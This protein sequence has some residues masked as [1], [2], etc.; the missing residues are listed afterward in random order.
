M[1][2]GCLCFL[3]VGII[4]SMS[5]SEP[6]LIGWERAVMAAEKVKDRLRRAVNALEN[7]GIGYAVAGGNAVA[8]WISRVDEDAVRNTRDVNIIV[9]RSDFAA[10]K[11]ALE[12]A[13]FVY[14]RLMDV[15]VFIDGPKGK[16]SGGVHLLFAGERV[17]PDYALPS[18]QL[19]ETETAIGKE[20]GMQFRVVSL[21][22]LV[23]MK[24]LSNCDK[25]RTHLR[26]FV[27]VGLID[28]T[29]P[30]RFPPELAAR[31]QHV[32]DTPGG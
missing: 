10:V 15:D 25:D 11:A 3:G 18:P 24:L 30:T 9:R 27:G 17:Q 22:A 31:L 13:G 23:R 12:S 26:D 28:A 7:T 14:C 19:D 5:E 32:L 2:A 20:V 6:S 8:E 21:E 29:W 4:A 16:P 1:V